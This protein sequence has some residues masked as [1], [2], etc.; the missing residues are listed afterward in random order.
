[1]RII[2]PI[3]QMVDPSGI[4]VRRDKERIFV[5]R[6]EYIIEPGSKAALEAALQLKDT[7]GAEVVAISVGS[8]QADDA[9]REAL[10]MG[11]DGARLLC[12][13]AFEEAD[14]SVTVRVLAAAVQKLGGAELI[15]TG[16]ES[17]DTGAGQVG[18]RLAE[19]LGFAQVTDVCA[20][21]TANGAV[22]ATRRWASSYATLLAS[23]PAVVTVAPEAFPPR[24]AHGTRIMKAYQEWEVTQW[25]AADLDLDETELK[26]CLSFRGESFPPPLEVGE[27]FRGDPTVV[28]REVVAALR[29]QGYLRAG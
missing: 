10:A 20:L 7:S 11:C 16:R 3:K 14:I 19:L 24:Y 12:D 2:V 28:A 26:P 8:L 21:A 27:Q 22:R 29:R 5:N 13:E 1:M 17:G 23:L 18:P 25:T 4:T 6:E 9:L 15:V